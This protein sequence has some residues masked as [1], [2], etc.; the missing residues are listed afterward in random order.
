MIDQSLQ[1]PADQFM[2]VPKAINLH[3]ARVINRRLKIRI[4]LGDLALGVAASALETLGRSAEPEPDIA[5]P[6]T[7]AHCLTV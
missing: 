2:Q 4:L 5:R 6:G 7:G 3:Q 1:L